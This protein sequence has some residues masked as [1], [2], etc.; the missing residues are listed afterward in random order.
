MIGIPVGLPVK[1]GT[2]VDWRSAMISRL[3]DYCRGPCDVVKSSAGERSASR[4]D[5][6]TD[7]EWAKGCQRMTVVQKIS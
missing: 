5:I 4:R 3:S 1:S 2:G 7:R 6:V